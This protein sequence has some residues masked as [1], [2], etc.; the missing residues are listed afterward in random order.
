MHKFKKTNCRTFLH[1]F[2]AR[3]VNG[4][5]CFPWQPLIKPNRQLYATSSM[6]AWVP[7]DLKNKVLKQTMNHRMISLALKPQDVYDVKKRHPNNMKKPK[8]HFLQ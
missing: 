4:G 8:Y 6:Q 3:F 2:I 1:K 5:L 7:Q